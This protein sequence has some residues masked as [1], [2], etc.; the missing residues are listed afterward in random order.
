MRFHIGTIPESDSALLAAW[1]KGIKA[2]DQG[3]RVGKAL[4][5]GSPP[6]CPLSTNR[7]AIAQAA[8]FDRCLPVDDGPIFRRL[9]TD[10]ITGEH[11][12]QLL[13]LLFIMARNSFS[14]MRGKPRCDESS[15][16][17]V[18]MWNRQGQRALLGRVG[19]LG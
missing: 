1:I 3:G 17:A 4:Q 8:G 7:T 5:A 16:E 19:G 2:G 13:R 9:Q 14:I 18:K 15:P 12:L 10:R 6:V 11:P